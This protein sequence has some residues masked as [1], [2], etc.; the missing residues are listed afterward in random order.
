MAAIRETGDASH[1][2]PPTARTPSKPPLTRPRSFRDDRP[3][4]PP[5]GA[6]FP[7]EPDVRMPCP[8]LGHA[9]GG[10]PVQSRAMKIGYGRVSG[11]GQDKHET[12][13]GPGLAVRRGPRPSSAPGLAAGEAACS[14][15]PLT[16]SFGPKAPGSLKSERGVGF[17][18]RVFSE[19]RVSTLGGP[20]ARSHA[21]LLSRENISNCGFRAY[22]GCT[23]GRA[24]ASPRSATRRA[25]AS[26][27]TSAAI[28]CTIAAT[29]GRPAT[30]C[31]RS[32]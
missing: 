1:A 29:R 8:R 18:E 25:R 26:S 24:A 15:K 20:T 31:A 2:R 21:P 6:A 22:L 12:H 9:V 17:R 16:R 7:Q 10:L 27:S 19:A 11:Y 3:R 23:P 30:T 28:R 4:T 32:G 14:L 5:A 13:S